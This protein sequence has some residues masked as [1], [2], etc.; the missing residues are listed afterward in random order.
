[1]DTLIEFAAETETPMTEADWEV[2]H[3]I[4]QTL[5][6]QEMDVNELG[7]AIAYLRFAIQQ[8][9]KNAGT[10]FFNYLKTLV[11][12]GKSIGHSGKTPEYYRN[13][14]KACRSHLQPY[15]AKPLILLH[16][17]GWTARL[18][19]YYKEGGVIGE[20][21]TTP[22][23]APAATTQGQESQRQAEIRAI[24]QN[25]NFQV[26]QQVEATVKNIKGKE[27]TYELPGGIKLTVK[28]PKKYSE[29]S[30][31]QTVQV[32]ILELRE[33]GTPKKVKGVS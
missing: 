13:L 18:I 1:M 27:V 22:Q 10:Q 19:R 32:E 14:D 25:Q 7:K 31:E 4:A 24:A 16:V 30:V 12:Q 11:K 6:Q 23:T 33:N 17:L 28:E 3:T 21:L 15:Q 29:L 5:V 26:G 2:A 9:P 8:N 20:P